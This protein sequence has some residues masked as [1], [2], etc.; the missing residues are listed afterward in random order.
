MPGEQEQLSLIDKWRL[1]HAYPD[2]VAMWAIS[3]G[4]EARA[5]AFNAIALDPRV[6]QRAARLQ[7]IK[8]AAQAEDYALSLADSGVA[9]NDTWQAVTLFVRRSIDEWRRSLKAYEHRTDGFGPS[10]APPIAR[11]Q[12][13]D[14]WDVAWRNFPRVDDET[15]R[16]ATRMLHEFGSGILK[17]VCK[18]WDHVIAL[19]V[20]R[21]AA[22]L[23]RRDP[24]GCEPDHASGSAVADILTVQT[25][26]EGNGLS[27][28]LVG[29]FG[30]GK[31][32]AQALSLLRDARTLRDAVCTAEAGGEQRALLWQR[33]ID[34]HAFAVVALDHRILLD[35]PLDDAY[36]VAAAAIR[37]ADAAKE[38]PGLTEMPSLPHGTVSTPDVVRLNAKACLPSSDMDAQSLLVRARVTQHRPDFG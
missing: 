8:M 28:M 25:Y 11:V 21:Y 13:S 34:F 29:Y 15:G 4:A 37:Q 30:P 3:S 1:R 2:A 10:D 7:A 9:R 19:A 33:A 23:L 36:E 32:A 16:L 31:P 17:R 20:L 26:A 22:R 12:F 24:R 38:T 14:P 6:L 18:P 35:L 27:P 5:L